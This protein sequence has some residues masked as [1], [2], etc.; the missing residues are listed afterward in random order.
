M[1]K[2]TVKGLL[3]RLLGRLYTQ[4][5]IG[6]WARCIQKKKDPSIF[7]NLYLELMRDPYDHE[8]RKNASA[9]LVFADT[10][11][12]YEILDE[13][14]PMLDKATLKIFSSSEAEIY[15]IGWKTMVKAQVADYWKQFMKDAK[16]K[17][18]TG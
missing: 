15:Y 11:D 2:K 12:W 17:R 7:A 5:I 18:K 16:G 3:S 6:E 8:L 14:T 13:L 1:S 4:E 9:F 10:R